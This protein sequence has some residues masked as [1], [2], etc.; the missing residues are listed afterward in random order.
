VRAVVA[1]QHD[2]RDPL[3]VARAGER[4]VGGDELAHPR[5]VAGGDRL[6]DVHGT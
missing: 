6:E 4:R 3:P 1:R 2:R 5:G